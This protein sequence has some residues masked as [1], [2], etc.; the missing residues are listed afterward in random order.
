MESQKNLSKCIGVAG[1]LWVAATLLFQGAEQGYRVSTV[2]IDDAGTDLF[3]FKANKNSVE[4]IHEI[5]VKTARTTQKNNYAYFGMQRPLLKGMSNQRRIYIFIYAPR[6][7]KYCWVLT[8]KEIS[9]DYKIKPS[10]HNISFSTLK[11]TKE[12]GTKYRCEPDRLFDTVVAKVRTL[13]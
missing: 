4:S 3:L 11:S 13:Q 10:V 8:E 1:E 12:K 5:Q 2:D 6:D 7:V 9:E